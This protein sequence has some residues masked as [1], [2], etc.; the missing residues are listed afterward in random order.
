MKKIEKTSFLKRLAP[1]NKPVANVFI[2]LTVSCI[3]GC[4]FPTFGILITKML[5]SLME[6]DL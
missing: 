6:K 5:F 1:Y 3:Q 2:G 4:I